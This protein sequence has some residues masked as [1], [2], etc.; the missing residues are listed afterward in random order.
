MR[1][2]FGAGARVCFAIGMVLS[3]AWLG[4]VVGV[5]SPWFALIASFCFLG[6]FDLVHPFVPI[7]MPR[8]LRRVRSWEVRGGAYRAIGVPIFG[9][10]L[11]R[12]P[13]RRLNRRVYLQAFRG[14][15][16][17]VRRQIENAESAHFWGG[18]ATVPYLVLAW[19]R[20]WWEALM[21]V[22]LFNLVVNAYP[23]FHLRTIRAR[24]DHGSGKVRR[25]AATREDS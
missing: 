11:R 10:F 8:F 20:G 13:V 9:E 19:S 22:V 18:V 24:I 16:S 1:R 25:R 7:L 23:I 4:R 3:I 14:D 2:W 15:L 12:T 6:L 17:A 5:D 21:S